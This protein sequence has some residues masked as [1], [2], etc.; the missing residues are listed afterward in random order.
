MDYY[1]ILGV[2][3]N[4]STD[5]IKKAYKKL[6]LKYHPDRNNGDKEA[7]EKFKEINKANETLSDPDKRQSYDRFGEGGAQS[8]FSMEDMFGGDFMSQFFGGGNRNSG[9]QKRRGQDIRMDLKLSIEE[10]YNGVS[11]TFK[12]NRKIVCNTC[13]GAGGKSVNNCTSCNGSGQTVSVQR[14][15]FGEFRQ[16]THCHFCSGT[17]KMVKDRCGDCSGT[18][19]VNSSEDIKVDIPKGVHSGMTLQMGAH[20]S[21]SKDNIPGDLHIFINVEDSDKFKRDGDNIIYDYNISPIDLILGTEFT[22]LS[23]DKKKYKIEVVKGTQSGKLYR[24]VSKGM[25]VLNTNKF[26]DLY[27]RLNVIIPSDISTE[28]EKILLSLKDSETFKTLNY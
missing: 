3:K 5:E 21:F 24:M 16:V 13:S 22:F 6:A 17:G 10:V 19:L 15:P 18:G 9:K 26:G 7:E 28:E 23:I 4:A 25:P 12:L 11:K 14:T 1:E 2:N 27:V 8:S 20:G